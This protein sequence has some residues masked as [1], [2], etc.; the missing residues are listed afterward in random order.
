MRCAL[1]KF[2]DLIG[3]VKVSATLLVLVEYLLTRRLT[4]THTQLNKRKQFTVSLLPAL[5]RLAALSD[6]LMQ[7]KFDIDNR[8]QTESVVVHRAPLHDTFC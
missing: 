8:M 2:S 1:L 5:T 3:L 7:V 4:C 6:E